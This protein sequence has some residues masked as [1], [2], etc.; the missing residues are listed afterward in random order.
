MYSPVED[1]VRAAR[2]L[3]RE[4]VRLVAVN[5][6][7]QESAWSRFLKRPY[8]EAVEL[9]AMLRA[10]KDGLVDP[11]EAVLA[12][13]EFRKSFGAYLVAKVGGGKAFL[14]SELTAKRSVLATFLSA[15]SVQ[16]R[17][18]PEDLRKAESYIA[19]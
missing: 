17:H 3:R 1:M 16:T 7:I 9:A 14:S 15:T 6:D 10:R 4:R 19:R 11:V 5:V 18:N 12:V 8:H 13:P 2:L